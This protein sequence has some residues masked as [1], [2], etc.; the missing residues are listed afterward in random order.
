[1]IQV[2][3][4]PFKLSVCR[5]SDRNPKLVFYLWAP[6]EDFFSDL[7]EKALLR[8]FRKLKKY[9]SSYETL[10]LVESADIHFMSWSRM[11]EEVAA[12]YPAGVPAGINKIWY[13]DTSIPQELEFWEIAG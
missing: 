11:N 10:L 3:G 8:K 2:E 5:E 12:L 9:S 1:L 7:L 4:I 6:E 13:A